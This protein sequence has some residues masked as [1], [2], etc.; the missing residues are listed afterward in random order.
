MLSSLGLCHPETDLF[1]MATE[2]SVCPNFLWETWTLFGLLLS[3]LNPNNFKCFRRTASSHAGDSVDIKMIAAEVL[4]LMQS[5]F[6]ET[7]SACV[8]KVPSSFHLPSWNL[9]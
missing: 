4:A 6:S 8:L 5:G 9:K 7:I 2:L 3:L 1:V